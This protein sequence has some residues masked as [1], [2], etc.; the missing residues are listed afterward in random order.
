[1]GATLSDRPRDR[2]LVIAHRGA[3]AHA[4]DNTIEAIRLAVDHGADGIEIDA[5]M[6]ADGALVAHHDDHIPGLG[7]LAEHSL[8]EI[9]VRFPYIATLDEILAAS[10]DLI[11]N[12]EIK[13]HPRDADFDPKDRIADEVASWVDK[14]A[15]QVRTLISSF[16]PRTVAYVRS[17]DIGVSTGLLLEHGLGLAAEIRSA[18][19]KGHQW[20]LPRR[21]ALRFRPRTWV[22]RAHSSGV[23]IGTWTVDDARTLRRL[24]RGQVDAVITNDP[25]RARR[26]Y[27]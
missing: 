10:G 1:M 26:L 13:N 5:R 17:M 3:S 20:I 15:L 8:D 2:P 14:S 18:A 19:E 25:G 4:R 24:R 23:L 22:E 9:R 11:L 16:N 6:T 7:V 21:S 12:V 27:D